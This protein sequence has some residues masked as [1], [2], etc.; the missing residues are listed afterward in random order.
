[1]KKLYVLFCCLFCI[2]VGLGVYSFFNYKQPKMDLPE[3]VVMVTPSGTP[4]TFRNMKPKVRLLEFMY[5]RCPDICPGTTFKMKK[6][7]DHLIREQVFGSK[8]EFLT[9]TID[10][11]RDTEE[12]LKAYAKTFDINEAEGWKLLRGDVSGTKKLADEF[13][14]TYGGLGTG[15]PSHTSTVYLL[16]EDNVVVEEF[17][18]GAENFKEELVIEKIMARI[19]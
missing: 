4:F 2:G 3:S 18:M 14:F 9:V 11:S 16:N 1:M 5:T 6:V 17:G 10:P 12:V 13:N 7:K 15:R 8:V 19:D